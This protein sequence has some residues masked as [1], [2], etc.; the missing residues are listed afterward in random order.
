ML[1]VLKTWQ[2]DNLL[3]VNV[4]NKQ[5]NI[6]YLFFAEESFKTSIKFSVIPTSTAVKLTAVFIMHG[7]YQVDLRIHLIFHSCK[8]HCKYNYYH[9][10]YHCNLW[11]LM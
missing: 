2:Y 8:Y 11:W 1:M 4:C 7:D 5:V 6:V 10:K 9:C 3:Q